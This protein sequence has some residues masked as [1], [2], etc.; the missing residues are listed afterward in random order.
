M[1][2]GV[3]PGA[4]AAGLALPPL[5]VSYNSAWML[6]HKLMQV[7]REREDSQPLRGIVELDDACLGGEASGDQRG[8]GAAR[9]TPV[10]AAAQVS[11]AGRPERLRLSPV[12]GLRRRAVEAWACQ[13][14]QPG[15]VVRSDGLRCSRGCRRP[16]ASTHRGFPVVARAVARRPG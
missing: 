7:L 12:R 9:Q 6:K 5:G 16:A 15:T 11:A 1:R 13:Q 10:L 2:P 4:L 3:V 8:R 14:S